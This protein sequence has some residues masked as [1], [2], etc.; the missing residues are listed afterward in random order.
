VQLPLSC[1]QSSFVAVG[2]LISYGPNFSEMHRRAAFYVDRIL[3]G[4]TAAK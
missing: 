2:C 1:E 3:K 4:R